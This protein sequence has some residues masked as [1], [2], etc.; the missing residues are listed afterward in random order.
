MYLFTCEHAESLSVEETVGAIGLAREHMREGGDRVSNLDKATQL[1]KK[2]ISEGQGQSVTDAYFE[3][4][5]INTQTSSENFA[6]LSKCV[7]LFLVRN[8]LVLLVLIC[9]LVMWRRAS[10]NG[11]AMAQHQLAAALFTGVGVGG[12][13]PRDPGR[14]LVLEQFSA[15]SGTP[16]AHLSLGY[17]CEKQNHRRGF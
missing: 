2:I 10:E 8:K 12:L 1:Y 14:A 4:A 16:E 9:P 7:V 6:L 5:S 15:L 3:L 11:H 13:V 17:R